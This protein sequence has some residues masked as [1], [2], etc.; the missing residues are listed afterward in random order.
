MRRTRAR[1]GRE[2]EW[3][4]VEFVYT[5]LNEGLGWKEILRFCDD[6][7][8]YRMLHDQRKGVLK[9]CPGLELKNRTYT[10]R[11]ENKMGIL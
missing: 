4:E 10:H 5:T 7:S 9:K 6:F 8:E 2:R 11:L 3:V 1:V